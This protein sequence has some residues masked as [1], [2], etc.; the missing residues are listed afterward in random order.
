MGS[1][2]G[3]LESSRAFLNGQPGRVA[4]LKAY[5]DESGTHAGSPVVVVGLYVG[6]PKVW[7]EWTK[8]WNRNKKPIKVYHAV[9]C[10]NRIGEFDGWDRPTRDAFAAKLLPV[11]GRHSIIGITVGIHM[12]AFEAAMKPRPELRAMFG[13]PYASCFQWTV[14]TLISMLDEKGD[15]QRIAFFH[16]CNND[17]KDA[18]A[19]FAYVKT[20]KIL[21]K[22][23][24]TLAFGGKDDYVPLQAA[25]VLAYE[26]NH[27]LRDPDKPDRLPWKAMNPGADKHHPEKYRVRVLHYG[28]NNMQELISLLSGFREKLLAQGWDGKI[29]A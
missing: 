28:K 11:L 16:E 9:D 26:S 13:T 21:N 5:V 8:D 25:D 6:K 17:E 19:A 24:V 7:A 23:A 22:R 14:Q 12:G 3:V 4:V 29:V 15:K 20:H 2:Q 18:E 27:L 1:A 10:H